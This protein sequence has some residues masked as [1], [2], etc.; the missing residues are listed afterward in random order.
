MTIKIRY[1]DNVY[2]IVSADALQRLI[3]KGRIKMFY[4]Y[5]EKKWVAIGSDPIRGC[6]DRSAHLSVRERRT[7][8]SISNNIFFN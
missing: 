8:N 1:V 6:C 7:S 3:D 2:D 4:R 5:S